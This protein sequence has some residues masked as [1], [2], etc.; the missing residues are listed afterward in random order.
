MKHVRGWWKRRKKNDVFKYIDKLSGHANGSSTGKHSASGAA[1][2]G[3]RTEPLARTWAIRREGFRNRTTS[4]FWIG[5][6]AEE[7][8]CCGSRV[9]PALAAPEV[10]TER[11]EEAA[12][13]AAEKKVSKPVSQS[14]RAGDGEQSSRSRSADLWSQLAELPSGV[15]AALCR[16]PGVSLCRKETIEAPGS[17]LAGRQT[18]LLAG[19]LPPGEAYAVLSGDARAPHPGQLHLGFWGSEH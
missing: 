6:G 4:C 17:G 9:L 7:G 2:S 15:R 10:E 13:G 18:A 14:L 5:A 3:P 19:V 11:A 12:K 8:N 16:S 1:T